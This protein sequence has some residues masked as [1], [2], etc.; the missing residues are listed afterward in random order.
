MATVYFY[1]RTSKKTD[2]T[3]KINVRVRFYHGKKINLY[4]KSGLEVL[5]G[6]FSNETH[7]INKQA[8]YVD[9][10][11]DKQYL[12]KLEATIIGA[13]KALK[14]PPTSEWL[15][16][17]IDKYRF[18]DKYK[19]KK[20]TLFEF[21][22]S[23]IDNLDHRINQKTDKQISYQSKREFH[24]TFG[25][26][27]EYAKSRGKKI[28]FKDIDLDF[29]NDFIKYLKSRN[30]AQNTIGKKI[31]FLKIVL[32]QA[33][34]R[35]I[36]TNLA[37]KS[38]RFKAIAEETDNIYLSLSELDKIQNLDLSN[39][40]KLDRVRDLFLIGCWTGLRFSDWHKV[41]PENIEN[42]F[43]TLKQQK[44][45]KPVVIPIH[46]PVEN[47]LNKYEGNLPRPIS[48]QKFNEYLKEVARMTDFKEAITKQFTRGGKLETT[49]K[50]KWQMIS[51]HT[52]RRSFATNMYKA[53]IPSITIMAV[54]GHR[55]ESAFL[56]YIKVTPQEHAEKM[57]DMW[58][59]NGSHLKVAK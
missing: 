29:Y 59:N 39:K 23:V 55:T 38:K 46:P 51:T 1:I 6:H 17:V 34:D 33:T 45:N 56:K 7:T 31:R 12:D 41:R 48:N 30:L 54:T 4:A 19:E 36:N 37:F 24:V 42:G 49:I 2:P 43:I 14:E 53:G 5:P 11:K 57:R 10:D 16:T 58:L 32:N 40:P 47:I 44:T 18:P 35:G 15:N 13:Y 20:M 52:A 26:L 9:K 27:K 8:R 28:D 25:Y 3:K 50:P 22:Q 21:F